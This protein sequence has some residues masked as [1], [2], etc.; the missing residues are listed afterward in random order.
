MQA[1]ISNSGWYPDLG[2]PR[3]PASLIG[4]DRVEGVKVYRRDGTHIG[5]IK[6][7]MID[8]RGGNVAYAVVRLGGFLGIGETHYPIPWPL[9]T[10]DER[11]NGYV[12]DIPEAQL[13]NAPKEPWDDGDRGRP[14][15]IYPYYRI[16]PL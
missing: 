5:T 3:E 16:W 10:Y 7:I 13:R 14:F 6:R 8:K 15:D 1:Q 4:S 2:F 9:L 11:A 12:V